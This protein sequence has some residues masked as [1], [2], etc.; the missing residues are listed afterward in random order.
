MTSQ[1]AVGGSSIRVQIPAPLRGLAGGSAEVELAASDVAEAIA[2]LEALHPGF[3]ERLY[4]AAG[5][6][7]SY[8]RVFVND[9]DV[10]AL[11]DQR[12]PLKHGD[13]VAIVPAIAGGSGQRRFRT[14]RPGRPALP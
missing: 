6:L 1:S 11:Q 12:T 9:E 14:S 13:V 7:R 4:D 10:R 2:A 8:V 3:R 5:A